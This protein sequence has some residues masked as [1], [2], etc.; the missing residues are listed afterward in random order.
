M[1]RAVDH[2]AHR[3]TWRRPVGIGTRLSVSAHPVAIGPARGRNERPNQEHGSRRCGFMTTSPH[4]IG[5]QEGRLYDQT[6]TAMH[7]HAP[8]ARQP[9]ITGT[10]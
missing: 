10:I 5:S 7:K 3:D 8:R 2:I 1:N 6:Q 9:H 4:H